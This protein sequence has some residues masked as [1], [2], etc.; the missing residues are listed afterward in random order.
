MCQFST[1]RFYT[2]VRCKREERPKESL[3]TRVSQSCRPIKFPEYL[4]G[5]KCHSS[6]TNKIT[7]SEFDLGGSLAEDFNRVLAETYPSFCPQKAWPFIPGFGRVSQVS[8]YM[9]V[10]RF[11]A[12][13]RRFSLIARW[14]SS[15]GKREN[16]VDA[17]STIIELQERRIMKPWLRPIAGPGKLSRESLTPSGRWRS[18]AREEPS[19]A[20]STLRSFWP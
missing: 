14:R 12:P 13:W 6:S 19:S 18:Q 16:S 9:D 5:W 7:L 2:S 17:Q 11:D 10:T 8:D 3:L 1:T 4:I 20:P 15:K